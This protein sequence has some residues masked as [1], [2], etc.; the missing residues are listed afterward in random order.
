MAGYGAGVSIPG[1]TTRRAKPVFAA[2]TK[3]TFAAF[4]A[5]L[6][7]LGVAPHSAVAAAMDQSD[8]VLRPTDTPPERQNPRDQHPDQGESGFSARY[9]G[10]PE[11][12]TLASAVAGTL[13]QAPREQY[14]GGAAGV[15]S[16]VGGLEHPSSVNSAAIGDVEDKPA[17][18]GALALP[19]VRGPPPASGH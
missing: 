9:S 4:L 14:G 6:L 7:G 3:L 19:E 1:E 5:A 13:P 18:T 17:G 2:R 10:H 15:L 11:H 12:S 16:P 8:E